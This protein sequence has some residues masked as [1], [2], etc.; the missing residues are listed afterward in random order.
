M[1]TCTLSERRRLYLL[2]RTV[3]AR[4]YSDPL[5]LAG[6]ARRLAVSP[7]QLQ[8]VYMQ[9]G[10]ITFREDLAAR[11]MAAA[12]DLLSKRGTPVGEVARLVGYRH[13]SHFA[14][15][16]HDRYGVTPRS[17]RSR[18]CAGRA[19]TDRAQARGRGASNAAR[20]TQVRE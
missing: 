5:T 9:F 14:R 6:V 11:R 20:T 18:A 10:A 13:A 15:T 4:D 16:F 19:R 12:V 7:R 1:R 8:R 17:F 3:V 2:A